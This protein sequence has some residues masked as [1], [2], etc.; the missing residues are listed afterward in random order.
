MELDL[1]TVE[2]LEGYRNEVDSADPEIL[3]RIL[4]QLSGAQLH[5]DVIFAPDGSR[6]PV[7][8]LRA[9]T[10]R[11]LDRAV[12]FETFEPGVT[13]MVLEFYRG[14][15]DLAKSESGFLG[16]EDTNVGDPA[17]SETR[18]AAIRA[19]PDIR[20]FVYADGRLRVV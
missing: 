20:A 2:M 8:E 15:R 11:Q 18:A 1:R 7:K 5:P 19:F 16:D 4:M 17:R 12:P 6:R 3:T 13:S 14:W 9:A 10:V